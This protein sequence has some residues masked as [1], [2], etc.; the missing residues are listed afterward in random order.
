MSSNYE[1]LPLE[2]AIT[3][4]KNSS[5]YAGIEILNYS[6]IILIQLFPGLICAYIFKIIFCDRTDE[7][8]KTMSL[9][10]LFFELWIEFWCIL[11]LYYIFRNIIVKVPSPFDNL[12]NSGFKNNLVNE[13]R[14]G[15]I[16]TIVFIICNQSL[17]SKIRIFSERIFSK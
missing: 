15:Y 12:C 2:T 14:S 11:I 5:V 17:R 16:F 4:K 6:Y 1:S 8:Y 10:Q 3:T 9:S 13:T 7:E